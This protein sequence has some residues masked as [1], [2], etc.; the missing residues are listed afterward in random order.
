MQAPTLLLYI[1]TNILYKD[2][3]YSSVKVNKRWYIIIIFH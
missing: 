3:M 1:V 2:L